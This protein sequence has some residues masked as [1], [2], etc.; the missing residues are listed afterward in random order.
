MS[1]KNEVR[2]LETVATPKN[3]VAIDKPLAN[4][5][6]DLNATDTADK[7]TAVITGSKCNELV[8]VFKGFT[9]ENFDTK[10][11]ALY[12][13]SNIKFRAKK[14]NGKSIV[15][16]DATELLKTAS[17]V[18]STVRRYVTQEKMPVI[19]GLTYSQIKQHFIAKKPSISDVRKSQNKR[20]KA[21]SDK[22]ITKALQLFDDWN[23]Q[24]NANNSIIKKSI[25]AP[26]VKKVTRKTLAHA[27]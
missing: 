7:E 17:V 6:R 11:I 27:S 12:V 20:V 18:I 24:E 26:L 14:E 25:K 22:N 15:R 5:V 21:L 8:Q 3:A 23:K 10:R 4:I 1:N 16:D 19:D 2:K 9:A 13:E